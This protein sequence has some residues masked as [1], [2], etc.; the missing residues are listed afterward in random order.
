MTNEHKELALDIIAG[1]K[2]AGID[3]CYERL[4]ILRDEAE[5]K[6]GSIYV[7]EEAKVKPKR[8]T[9]VA[10]GDGVDPDVA[11][12]MQLGMRCMFTKYTPIQFTVDLP[13]GRKVALDL[14][15][16][17]DMYLKWFGDGVRPDETG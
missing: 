10:I 5:E 6:I 1:M 7:P 9:L 11:A 13:D 15:H 3:V 16:V 4:A 14:I 17:S 12:K 2:V 8:G